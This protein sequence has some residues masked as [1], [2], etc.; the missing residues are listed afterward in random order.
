MD[1][2]LG[3]GKEELA[4]CAGVASRVVVI[5]NFP[6]FARCHGF[7]VSGARA[8]ARNFRCFDRRAARDWSELS[9]HGGETIKITMDV[10]GGSCY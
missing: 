8:C 1:G 4:V 7:T 6:L 9:A 3:S 2:T 5:A 10:L